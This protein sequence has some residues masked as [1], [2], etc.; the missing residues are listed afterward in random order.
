MVNI[1]DGYAIQYAIKKGYPVAIITGANTNAVRLRFE[2]LGVK[3]IYMVYEKDADGK[4][5]RKIIFPWAEIISHKDTLLVNLL[6]NVQGRSGEENLNASVEGLEYQLTDAIRVLNVKE[7][8]KIAFL[9]GNGEL[10]EP[11]VYDAITALS[12]YF[13]VDRGALGNDPKA[14]DPYKVVIVAKPVAS[15][16]ESEKFILDQYIMRGGSVLWL[17]DGSKID[18][19]YLAQTGQATIAP[20]DVNL[21]DM[22]FGYGIRINPD[23]VQDVQCASMALSFSINALSSSWAGTGAVCR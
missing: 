6:T 12:R 13:Q 10:P 5:V 7:T 19:N 2:R 23:I 18:N 14:L 20:L 9:E 3:D 17:I 1:K 22:L 4:A 8:R 21:A 11:E 15:F 16:S